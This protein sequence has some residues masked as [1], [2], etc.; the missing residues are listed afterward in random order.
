MNWQ[1]FG[2]W[3][4]SLLENFNIGGSVFAGDNQQIAS[5]QILRTIVAIAGNAVAG[6]P[7]LGFNNNVRET[8]DMAFWDLHMAWFYQQLALIGEWG[9][10]FQDYSTN[11][12]LPHEN[13]R[14]RRS[15]SRRSYLLTG[16]TRSSIGIVKPNSPFSL[17][18]GQFGTG[19]IEPYFRY[20]YMDIGS[21]IFTAGFSDPNL[22][23]NRVFQT[24][25]GVNWHITQYVKCRSTGTTPSSTSPC[26]SPRASGS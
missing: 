2:E 11:P 24:H 22:W 7:F 5:P 12:A 25:T 1:P 18:N 23:A 3:K 19:A 15:T 17:H 16:E 13:S 4:G 26:S 6:V 9:S 8:G 21:Q 14:S 10:G 20:E